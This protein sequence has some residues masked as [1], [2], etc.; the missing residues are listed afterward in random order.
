MVPRPCTFGSAQVG[1]RM[2]ESYQMSLV[3]S[4]PMTG[5]P[6]EAGGFGWPAPG[7]AGAFVGTACAPGSATSAASFR[8]PGV[9]TGAAAEDVPGR[10][11]RPPGAAAAVVPPPVAPAVESGDASAPASGTALVTPDRA[12]EPTV[13]GA[14][15]PGPATTSASVRLE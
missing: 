6:E 7:A 2:G 5:T 14:L 11:T 1:T 12:A 10:D 15:T 9:A 13:A 8:L 3:Q 4:L